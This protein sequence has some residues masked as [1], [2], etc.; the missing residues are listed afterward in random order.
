MLNQISDYVK[1][2]LP[3]KRKT[4]TNGWVSFN[5]PCCIHNGETADTRGRGGIH[6]DGN[7]T[8][9]YHCFN[10]NYKA[11]YQPGR[12]LAYKFR[13]LLEWLGAPESE[14]KRLVIEAIRI[15]DLI[16]PEE[17][18]KVAPKE[19]IVIKKRSLPKDAISYSEL[20]TFYSVADE[21][22]PLPDDLYAQLVYLKSRKIDTEKY[23]FYYSEEKAHQLNKRIVVPFYWKGEIIGYT[24]RAVVD[25]IPRYHNNYESNFVFNVDKQQK[26]W[27]FVIVTEGPFDAMSIDGVAVLGNEINENQ[28]EIIDSLGKEVIVVA[29]TDPIGVN[30]INAAI[31]YGW[32]VSFP[33]WQETCK[34]INEAVCKYGK[35]FVLK[36]IIDAKESNILKIQLMRKKIYPTYKE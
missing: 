36:S 4:A 2:I 13:K 21:N 19:E 30:T 11:S 5:C 3:A 34:D 7:G 1:S 29:D 23:E 12:H 20:R 17:L 28:A 8:I 18:D 15:K 9:S 27:K 16:D 22:T 32:S 26:D 6:A 31:K 14:I 24:G 35:L 33:I 25:Y 10:C